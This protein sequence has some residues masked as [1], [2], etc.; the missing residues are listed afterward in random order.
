M[1]I[2]ALQDIYI[3]FRYINSRQKH[4]TEQR[5][6]ILIWQHDLLSRTPHPDQ[7][8]SLFFSASFHYHYRW[9]RPHLDFNLDYMS[10]NASLF[11]V[12]NL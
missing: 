8:I 3:N 5:I 11:K 7:L 6:P 12:Q 1:Q 9:C 10:V 2:V 4:D